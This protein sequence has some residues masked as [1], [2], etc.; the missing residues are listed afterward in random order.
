[1][2]AF[3]NRTLRDADRLDYF[4]AMVNKPFTRKD[5]MNTFKNLS[6]ATASRDLLK[7]VKMG[8]ITKE[9]E[10]NQTVYRFT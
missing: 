3:N 2:L 6:S 4:K 10:K 9:G 1:L 7:G 8:L 5:Y